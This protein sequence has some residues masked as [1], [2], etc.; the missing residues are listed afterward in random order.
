MYINV[1]NLSKSEGISSEARNL[2]FI[3]EY[4]FQIF[5]NLCRN[6]HH[7]IK[8]YSIYHNIM[9]HNIINMCQNNVFISH[10]KYE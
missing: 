6:L 7:T 1:I 9:T 3:Y 5:Y 2:I 10:A 4:R 8:N